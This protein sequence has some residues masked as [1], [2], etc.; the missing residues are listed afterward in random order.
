MKPEKLQSGCC[1]SPPFDELLSNAQ[2][3]SVCRR[4]GDWLLLP[5]AANL[6]AWRERR[7]FAGELRL[8]DSRLLI[9]LVMTGASM[10]FVNAKLYV[11]IASS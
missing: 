2:A 6:L 7:M 3:S 11:L 4:N 1:L 10:S 8:E 9:V 5:P